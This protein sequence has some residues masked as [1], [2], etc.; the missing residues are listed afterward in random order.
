MT[1]IKFDKILNK[2]AD[3][4]CIIINSRHL[5]T[6]EDHHSIFINLRNEHNQ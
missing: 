1:R 4:F 6:I 2:G 3:A 5:L